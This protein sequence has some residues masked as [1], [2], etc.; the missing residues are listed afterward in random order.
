MGLRYT[1]VDAFTA[2][3]F[4]GNPAVVFLLPTARETEWL[5]AVASEMN[6]PET[7][8]L[9]KTGDGYDL[10]WFTPA[11][12]VDLAGHPTLAS[13]H[14]LWESGL[15]PPGEPVRFH[16]RS[17]LLV[18]KRKQDWIRLDF[19]STPASPESVSGVAEALGTPV[20][21]TG[22]SPFDLLAELSSEQSL[23]DLQPD[24][25]AIARFP[26]RG[27]IATARAADGGPYDFVSRFFAPQSGINEDPVTGSAHC[28]LGPYWAGKL[29]KSELLAYQA[30]ARGGTIRVQVFKERVALEGQATTVAIGELL[31][32]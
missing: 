29:G 21:W 26:V 16:T 27:V 28:C 12:E 3:R 23:R 9:V 24:L 31:A 11:V 7:A 6:Q 17:G 20:V 10:R 5:Q 18:A 32:D 8:F 13:A 19:P 2:K 15:V 4:G 22:K 1:L 25:T 30:S 14:Y